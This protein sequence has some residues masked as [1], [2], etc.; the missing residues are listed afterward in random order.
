VP[1][2]RAIVVL[3]R[4]TGR[5]STSWSVKGVSGNFPMALDEA[6]GH[7]IVAF[8]NPAK[9]G[10]FAMQTGVST[11]ERDTCDD[12]DDV[13]LDAK[14]KRVYVSCG[15]GY[16]DVFDAGAGSFRLLARIPT[17]AGA[18]TSLFLPDEDRYVAA[19]RAQGTEPAALWVYRPVP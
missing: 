12:S 17:I 15:A 1:K 13:F 4:S 14:R 19:A 5:E 18:R 3:D 2:T 9:L 11:A 8:R 16:I 6:S 7:V 10:V